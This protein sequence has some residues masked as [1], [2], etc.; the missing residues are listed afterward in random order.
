M[1]NVKVKIFRDSTQIQVFSKAIPSEG[2]RSN[3]RGY[4]PTG[5]D[6]T[7]RKFMDVP[8]EKDV[9]FVRE[10]KD[11]DYD[12]RRS[13]RRTVNS[14]YDYSRSNNWDWFLTLTL[15]PKKVNRYD[16]QACC[17]KLKA[18]LDY[19]RRTCPDMK[20]LIVPEQHKDGA[21]HYHALFSDC[22][23]LG[24]VDSGRRDS[25]GR[26]IWNVGRYRLGFSTATR[27]TD[28]KKTA[29][30]ICKYITKELCVAT[31][32]RKRYWVSSNLNKPIVI[33]DFSDIPFDCRRYFC[34][35]N[36]AYVKNVEIPFNRICYIEKSV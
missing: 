11:S 13:M 31:V 30:Y 18:W 4:A 9:V 28:L 34:K 24:F 25:K 14:I 3:K 10:I 6:I 16:Y 19:M 12:V 33:E 2:E 22:S 36:S 29:S 15:D 1:Y 35:Q 5:E 27:V 26:I 21:W 23:D 7:G 17:K 32:G 8:F 20:Y